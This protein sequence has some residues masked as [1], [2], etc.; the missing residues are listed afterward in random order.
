M[1]P[2]PIT[3]MLIVQCRRPEIGIMAKYLAATPFP[4]LESGGNLELLDC[5]PTTWDVDDCVHRITT[6][7]DGGVVCA[8]L[9]FGRLTRC[10][11]H[12]VHRKKAIG[13]KSW[14]KSDSLWTHFKLGHYPGVRPR[15]AATAGPCRVQPREGWLGH[16][17]PRGGPALRHGLLHTGRQR[18]DT[19]TTSPNDHARPALAPGAG[20]ARL[21]GGPEWQHAHGLRA[22]AGAARQYQAD[23][24]RVSLPGGILL[25]H[26]HGRRLLGQTGGRILPGSGRRKSAAQARDE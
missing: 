14:P 22:R 5:E 25:G 20:A 4:V 21:H 2:K 8:T 19:R 9:L 23:E 10:R 7:K 11:K 16:E 3:Y 13:R 17:L 15:R 12:R 18:R 1:K 26:D 24:L 6:D